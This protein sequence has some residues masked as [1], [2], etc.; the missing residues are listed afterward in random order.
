[1]PN[2]NIPNNNKKVNIYFY[3]QQTKQSPNHQISCETEI[4]QLQQTE[5]LPSVYNSR[6]ASDTY[7]R[8]Y[9]ADN[10]YLNQCWLITKFILSTTYW[11][12]KIP[13]K[14]YLKMS[15]AKWWPSCLGPPL[16]MGSAMNC[17]WRYSRYFGTRSHCTSKY[18]FVVTVPQSYYCFETVYCITVSDVSSM[19]H[20]ASLA[21][22]RAIHLWICWTV[23]CMEC[24]ILYSSGNKITNTVR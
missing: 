16:L 9:G 19:S 1:M 18:E 2:Q 11:N 13:T 8:L 17:T 4:L 21:T 20:R 23:V 5:Y 15:F 14:N 12:T 22:A 10:G 7:V 24:I 3:W 6:W